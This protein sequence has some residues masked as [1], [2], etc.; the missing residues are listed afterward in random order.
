V[1]GTGGD[2][3]GFAPT[4]DGGGGRRGRVAGTELLRGRG[5]FAGEQALGVRGGNPLS[6]LGDTDGNNVE[7]GAI[8]GL[9][10]GGGG[11]ERDF[12]FAAAPAKENADSDLFHGPLPL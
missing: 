2:D 8:D 10:D 12:M 5:G 4:E 3:N 9:Q 1:A 11:E 6:L 7:F